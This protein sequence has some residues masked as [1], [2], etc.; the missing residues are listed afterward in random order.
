MGWVFFHYYTGP[1][2]SGLAGLR[3]FETEI[4]PNGALDVAMPGPHR[5]GK[6]AGPSDDWPCSLALLCEWPSPW[7]G[8]LSD[9]GC[10]VMVCVLVGSAM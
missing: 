1:S 7:T 5:L 10:R 3:C 9:T 8:L 4:E 2:A 6:G